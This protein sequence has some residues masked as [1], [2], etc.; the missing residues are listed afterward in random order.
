MSA[1]P[2]PPPP[3][4]PAHREEPVAQTNGSPPASSSPA[5]LAALLTKSLQEAESLKSELAQ[6]K[7]R[8]DKAERLLA[9]FQS[10]SQ[11]GSPNGSPPG[12]SQGA[13]SKPHLSEA[14]R[15]AILDSDA[16]ADAAER[17]RDEAEARLR[18]LQEYWTDVDR[19]FSQMD[20]RTADMRSRWTRYIESGGGPI[21]PIGNIPTQ[22]ASVYL[23][24][25][26]QQHDLPLPPLP[27]RS[28]RM[29]VAGPSQPFPS[30]AWTPGTTTA[31]FLGQVPR[32]PPSDPAPSATPTVGATATT[33]YLRPTPLIPPTCRTGTL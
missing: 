23:P 22:N 18:M 19:F 29:R 26:L 8:A 25:A 5:Q 2:Q 21:V 9:I 27:S 28:A 1:S 3:A 15:K 12:S 32:H 17:A 13:S 16:R 20:A 24:T 4:V 30:I 11:S 14:T 33:A 6:V 7:R 31:S 10:S